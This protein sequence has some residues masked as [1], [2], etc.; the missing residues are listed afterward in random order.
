M[1]P[2]CG[3]IVQHVSRLSTWYCQVWYSFPFQNIASIQGTAE[4]VLFYFKN[5]N[6]LRKLRPELIHDADGVDTIM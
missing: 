1:F 5:N 3:L 2:H 4:E 6:I